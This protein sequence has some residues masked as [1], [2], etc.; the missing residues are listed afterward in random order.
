[1]SKHVSGA[2]HN[3]ISGCPPFVIF[4]RFCFKIGTG[5]LSPTWESTLF[6]LDSFLLCRPEFHL[7]ASCDVQNTDFAG[8]SPWRQVF[9]VSTSRRPAAERGRLEQLLPLAT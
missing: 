3:K 4:A 2:G 5:P 8:A 7:G 9:I 1:M 6:L